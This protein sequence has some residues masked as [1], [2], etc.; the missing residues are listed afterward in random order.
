[1]YFSDVKCFDSVFSMKIRIIQIKE[2]QKQTLNTDKIQDFK[3]I[4]PGFWEKLKH[5][6]GDVKMLNMSWEIVAG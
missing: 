1:M 4:N 3:K 6:G 5:T 2:T